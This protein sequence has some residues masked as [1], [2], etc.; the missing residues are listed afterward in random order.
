MTR[1]KISGNQGLGQG[2]SVTG[3]SVGGGLTDIEFGDNPMNEAFTNPYV[4]LDT[5]T[6]IRP[7]KRPIRI[8]NDNS[9]SSGTGEDVLRTL[10][11]PANF[12]ANQVGVHVIASGVT[13]GTNDK[14]TV[15]LKFGSTT[16]ATMV[17]PTDSTD[18]WR[19]EAWIN[20][21]IGTNAQKITTTILPQHIQGSSSVASGTTSIAVTHDLGVAPA[22]EAITITGKEDPTNST[23]THWVDTITA[24]QFTFNVENDPGA[25]NFD[26]GWSVKR[27]ETA[28]NTTAAETITGTIALV[29]TGEAANAGDTVNSDIW[30]VEP[31]YG[32]RGVD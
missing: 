22:A 27:A 14:K 20:N 13:T 30:I 29:L 5:A 1:G 3:M 18:Q 9:D 32:I 10:T 7:V 19:M 16:I 2:A 17:I 28:L 12:F 11:F 21:I 26:F 6:G 15:K 24:T 25:S 8:S 23:G 31:M 4:G